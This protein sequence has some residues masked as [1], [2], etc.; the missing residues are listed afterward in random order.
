MLIL[1]ERSWR[2]FAIVLTSYGD[3]ASQIHWRRW[4]T[5]L[6]MWQTN[7]RSTRKK[8]RGQCLEVV[9]MRSVSCLLFTPVGRLVSNQSIIFRLLVHHLN[10][11]I[12]PF[13]F[14]GV[15]CIK[16]Y[17]KEKRGRNRKCIKPQEEN[18]RCEH[19]MKKMRVTVRVKLVVGYWELVPMESGDDNSSDGKQPQLR[20]I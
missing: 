14:L 6:F 1:T 7:Q 10:L 19:Q 11:L 5:A 17:L 2:F 8:W 16:E 3:G 9:V 13:L 12:I 18:A 20:R 4:E 15:H